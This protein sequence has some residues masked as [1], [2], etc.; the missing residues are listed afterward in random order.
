MSCGRFAAQYPVAA[1]P[2]VHPG[3]IDP[4]HSATTF[5]PPS[6]RSPGGSRATTAR[7]RGLT[8]AGSS[9]TMSAPPSP[10]LPHSRGLAAPRNLH[11]EDV[12]DEDRFLLAMEAEDTTFR[13]H[14]DSPDALDSLGGL[15]ALLGPRY[16]FMPREK[17]WQKAQILQMTPFQRR[18]RREQERL[19]IAGTSA[20]SL[21]PQ[22]GSQGRRKPEDAPDNDPDNAARRRL[23]HLRSV[24][25]SA[26]LAASTKRSRSAGALK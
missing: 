6:P 13:R 24:E 3:A 4:R 16:K 5:I 14:A 7:R 12:T 2:A 10:G 19:G 11:P 18:M 23:I 17:L 22:A 20:A 9:V 25:R 26:A 15:I 1:H 8:S 21:L